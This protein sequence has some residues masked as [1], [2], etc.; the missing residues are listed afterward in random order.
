MGVSMLEHELSMTKSGC[1]TLLWVDNETT[2]K[3]KKK[4][5]MTF[6]DVR[7]ML[8]VVL[9]SKIIPLYYVASGVKSWQESPA[10]L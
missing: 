5:L 4:E 3:W 9:I 2:W 8:R 10:S 6:S 1:K 7:N